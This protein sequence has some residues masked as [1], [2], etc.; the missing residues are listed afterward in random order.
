MHLKSI[1]KRTL[2]ATKYDGGKLLVN[3]I[4]RD[5][6]HPLHPGD[7]VEIQ[8]PPEKISM[9]LAVE[10]G[11][12]D[13]VYED[14][15]LIV[16]N[17]PAGQS[18]IPSR[19]HPSGTIANFLAGKFTRE[20]VPST[21]HIVTR[22]DRNTSGLI[23][24]A[25]NRHIHHLLGQQM[26]HSDFFRRYEAIVEGHIMKDAFSIEEPIGRE[27]GS[28]IK[29][30][31]REDGQYARTDVLVSERFHIKGRALSRVNL[32][33]HTG[34]THQ[35]RVHMEW[36]GHPLVGD[37]LYGG[38]VLFISRQALHCTALMFTHPLSGELKVFESKVPKDM[39]YL[40]Q[41]K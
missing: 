9:G 10:H 40:N 11:E 15:A 33:L 28:I 36:A 25:R 16:V 24:I 30:V 23:C 41:N 19:D 1:S 22:L 14:D 4:E 6:R 21:V 35:I 20:R 34:R 5:V 7:E 38:D 27:D 39:R 26:I 37:D 13:L 17:K 3:G 8:F 2:T 32:N 29:R 12:L 31:V 18:T